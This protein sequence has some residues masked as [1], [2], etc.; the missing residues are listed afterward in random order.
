MDHEG[1]IISI[2]NQKDLEEARCVASL[3]LV[4]AKSVDEAR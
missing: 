3:R 4:M 2:T 1:D